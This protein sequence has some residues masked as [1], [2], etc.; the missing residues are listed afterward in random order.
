[1]PDPIVVCDYD[2]RWSE[3]YEALR[4]RVAAALGDLAA[5]IDHVG[6]TS[7][8]GL[9]AKPTIDII[10]MLRSLDDLSVAIERLAAIGYRH[11]GDLGISGREAFA[12]PPGYATH[13][14]HLYV[15]HP[16]WPGYAEQ[17]AFRD[18]LRAHPDVARA[19][20]DLK[21][22]LAIAHRN[23][24]RAYTDAKADF[25]KDVLARAAPRPSSDGHCQKPLGQTKDGAASAS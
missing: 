1:M 21:R 12:T 19:Y 6:S 4:A 15:C 25:V 22:A 20:G 17:V 11:E 3:R 13:D 7:V 18:F 14:H 5:R 8:P 9:A 16:D 10:V 24:R 23:D 2:P